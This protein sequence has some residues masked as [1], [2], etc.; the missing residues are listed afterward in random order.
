MLREFKRLIALDLTEDVAGIC[1]FRRF[2]LIEL[3]N[4]AVSAD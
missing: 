3:H 1:G 2:R 4:F